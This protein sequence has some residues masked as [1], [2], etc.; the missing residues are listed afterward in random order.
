VVEFD[1]NRRR[2]VSGPKANLKIREVSREL[3]ARLRSLPFVYMSHRTVTIF[4]NSKLI[5]HSDVT[6]LLLLL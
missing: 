1:K 4:F 6:F 5:V 3:V 2:A